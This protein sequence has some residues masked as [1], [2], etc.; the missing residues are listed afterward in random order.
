[1]VETNPVLLGGWVASESAADA[2][3]SR[4]PTVA[5]SRGRAPFPPIALGRSWAQKKR[6]IYCAPALARPGRNPAFRLVRPR[7]LGSASPG[8]SNRRQPSA[9]RHLGVRSD[10][11]VVGNASSTWVRMARGSCFLWGSPQPDRQSETVW[12]PGRSPGRARHRVFRL[13]L[14]RSETNGH[15]AWTPLRCE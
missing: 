4:A 9:G 5:A 11:R 13:L 6:S 14:S 15:Q 7:L 1:V 8:R 2:G 12:V 3:V 10:S